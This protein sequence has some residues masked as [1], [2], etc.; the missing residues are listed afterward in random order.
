MDPL[1]AKLGGHDETSNC[2]YFEHLL[3]VKPFF[4]AFH[5]MRRYGG[6]LLFLAVSFPTF[7]GSATCF[8]F[9]G[10]HPSLGCGGGP[11]GGLPVNRVTSDLPAAGSPVGISLLGILIM[12]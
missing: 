1:G 10:G 8:L 9:G 5:S 12:R 11:G 6:S 4:H 7:P 3:C 2:C